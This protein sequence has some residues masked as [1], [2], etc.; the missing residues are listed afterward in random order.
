MADINCQDHPT[1][2]KLTSKKKF[3]P[4][5]LATNLKLATQAD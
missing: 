5:H 2:F 3:D 1:E 4:T